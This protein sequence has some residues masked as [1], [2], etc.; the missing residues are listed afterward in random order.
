MKQAQK[1]IVV[2]AALIALNFNVVPGQAQNAAFEAAD[3]ISPNIHT[4]QTGGYWAVGNDEGSFRIIVTAGG[5]EHVSHL[6]YIQ[7]LRNNTTTQSYELVRTVWVSELNSE[8]G[9]VL[10]VANLFGDEN[11]FEI[12][13]T[14]NSRGGD[15]KR[16]A[17]IARGEGKYL[18]KPR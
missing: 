4:V 15:A 3:N 1:V 8:Q 10:E 16:F 2:F 6:L 12:N 13:V 7:W 11:A 18:I 14:A 17:I 5:V 9:Q